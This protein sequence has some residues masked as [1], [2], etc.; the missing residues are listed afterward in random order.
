MD[1]VGKNR[2][3][4]AHG[5]IRIP[6]FFA[7]KT[8]QGLVKAVLLHPCKEGVRHLSF[9][10][11]QL[12]HDVRVDFGMVPVDEELRG[13]LVPAVLEGVDDHPVVVVVSDPVEYVGGSGVLGDGLFSP[14]GETGTV[15]GAVDGSGL[16]RGGFGGGA[17]VLSSISGDR[18]GRDPV[19]SVGVGGGGSSGGRHCVGK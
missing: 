16:G 12:F 4:G 8:G 13:G 17:G 15:R 11:S 10:I 14:L 6:H 7:D 3:G 2:G 18:F 19:P 5:A 1:D 9:S